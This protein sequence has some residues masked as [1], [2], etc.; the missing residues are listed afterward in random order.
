MLQL[1]DDGVYRPVN[2][3]VTTGNRWHSVA[4][5]DFQKETIKL[6]EQALDIHPKGMRDISTLTVALSLKDLPEIRERIKLLRQSVLSLENDNEPD[7]VFQINIQ[8]IPV[9]VPLRGEI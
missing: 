7:T 3:F 8:V 9:T 4:I 5:H 1:C 6:S 2:A